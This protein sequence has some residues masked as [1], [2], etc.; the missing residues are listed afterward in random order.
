MKLFKV[1]KNFDYMLIN[2][3]DIL[4]RFIKNNSDIEL[5]D[6]WIDE[7]F[8]YDSPDCIMLIKQEDNIPIIF[9]F[10]NFNQMKELID[11]LIEK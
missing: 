10:D 3:Q 2:Q 6:G 8:F 11:K 1:F 4:K 7:V 9:K 5:E